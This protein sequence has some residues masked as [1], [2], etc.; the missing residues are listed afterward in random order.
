MFGGTHEQSYIA[1]V[2]AYA[3]C[4]GP[5]KTQHHCDDQIMF[6]FVHNGHGADMGHGPI[7]QN[8]F[9]F[10]IISTSSVVCGVLVATARF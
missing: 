3:A 1:H 5:H 8:T 4:I 10:I 2:I 9:H 6:V 7:Y